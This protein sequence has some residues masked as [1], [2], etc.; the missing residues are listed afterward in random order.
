MSSTNQVARLGGWKIEKKNGPPSRVAVVEQ[1]NIETVHAPKHIQAAGALCMDRV[2]VLWSVPTAH[3]PREV[4]GP[5]PSSHLQISRVRQLPAADSGAPMKHRTLK[6]DG[7]HDSVTLGIAFAKGYFKP[8]GPYVMQPIWAAQ[9]AFGSFL[10][11]AMATSL[12]RFLDELNHGIAKC[13]RVN[14]AYALRGHLKSEAK[15]FKSPLIQDHPEQIPK[16]LVAFDGIVLGCRFTRSIREQVVD[17]KNNED[18]A[19]YVMRERKAIAWAESVNRS[20]ALDWRVKNAKS[21]P[22]WPG[23]KALYSENNAKGFLLLKAAYE[24]ISSWL[25][26]EASVYKF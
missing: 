7:L 22:M 18:S 14:T 25:E 16:G 3:R 1:E 6:D 19:V 5:V 20:L 13:G 26:A 9:S 11:G 12:Y 21:N 10:S 24:I 2:A 17:D 8:G 15:V 4:K 23:C